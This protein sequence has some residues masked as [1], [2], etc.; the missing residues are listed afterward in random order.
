MVQYAP[1]GSDLHVV[2]QVLADLVERAAGGPQLDAFLAMMGAFALIGDSLKVDVLPEQR[3]VLAS[4]AASRTP[5]IGSISPRCL[6][7]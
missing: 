5:A 3:V 7:A 6:R 4:P 2:V 1:G